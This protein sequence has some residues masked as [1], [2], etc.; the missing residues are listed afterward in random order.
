MTMVSEVVSRPLS[1]VLVRLTNQDQ[2]DL[3][4]SA[5]VKDFIRLR[6]KEVAEIKQSFEQKYLMPFEEFK[7]RW[8]AGLIPNLYSYEVEKDYWEW[9]SAVTNEISLHELRAL[10]S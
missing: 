2:I 6:L 9:E 8:H 5:L 1:Q 7:R 10:F 4:L 3:A